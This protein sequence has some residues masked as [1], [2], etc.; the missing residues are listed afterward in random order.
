VPSYP[1]ISRLGVV[2][3]RNAAAKEITLVD[4]AAVSRAVSCGFTRAALTLNHQLFADNALLRNE[5]RVVNARNAVMNLFGGKDAPSSGEV[6]LSYRRLRDALNEQRSLLATGYGAWL[7]H[8]ELKLGPSYDKLMKQFADNDLISNP[9]IADIERR[10]KEDFF[11]ARQRFV[12]LF[13]SG[14]DMGIS[15]EGKQGSLQMSAERLAL[16]A[17]LDHLLAQPFMQPAVGDALEATPRNTLVQW[18]TDQLARAVKLGEGHRKYLTEDL[19][20]FPTGMQEA[21]HDL[22]DYQ[23]AL[24]LVDLIGHAYTRLDRGSAAVRSCAQASS[25][26]YEMA[27]QQVRKLVHYS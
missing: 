26:S 18:D 10:S 4:H 11:R 15:A 23:Y 5:E 21:V 1:A 25:T 17:A 20:K 6:I 2:L 27:S 12:A 22:I 14:T 9:A 16:L 3:F 13:G 24:R 19:P 7:L 8:D